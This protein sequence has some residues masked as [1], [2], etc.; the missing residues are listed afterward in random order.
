MINNIIFK[1]IMKEIN[2]EYDVF[3]EKRQQHGVLKVPNRTEVE[4]AEVHGY[5]SGFTS[6]EAVSDDAQD[7]I[8]SSLYVNH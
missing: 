7:N 4:H 6:D 2:S 3:S 5:N 1:T 8:E